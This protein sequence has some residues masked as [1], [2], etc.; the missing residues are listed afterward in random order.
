MHKLK[1]IRLEKDLTQLQVQMK[2]GI[3]QSDYSKIER[4]LRYPT[5]EQLIILSELFGTSVDYL[6]DL[7]DAEKPYP[8]KTNP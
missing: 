3:D 7:T 6:L 2:T 5:V 8:R 1:K 4:G